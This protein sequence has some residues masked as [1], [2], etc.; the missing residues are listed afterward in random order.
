MGEPLS[1]VGMSMTSLR[2]APLPLTLESRGRTRL[3]S[4][5]ESHVAI[6]TIG[7]RDRASCLLRDI[8]QPL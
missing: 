1:P 5:T 4:R 7:A 8:K 2:L 3:R 6:R